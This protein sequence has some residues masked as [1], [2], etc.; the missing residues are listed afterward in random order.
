MTSAAA[1]VKAIDPKHRKSNDGYVCRC[2]VHDDRKASLKV[3]D[4]KD[5]KILVHCHAGCDSRDIIAELDRRGLWPKIE[6]EQRKPPRPAND[7]LPPAANDDQPKAKVKPVEVAKYEYFDHQTG[8]LMMQ[9]I[10]YEPKDF[11]QRRPESQPPRRVELDGRRGE[12]HPLQRPAR[13]PARQGHPRR[14]GREGRRQ[15]RRHRRRRGLQP[16]RRGQVAGQLLRDPARQGRRAGAG[17]RPAD[18]QEGDR[19]ADVAR[20][21]PPQAC[22]TGSRRSGRREAAGHRQVGQDPAPAGHAGRHRHQ[23]LAGDRRQRP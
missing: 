20:R 7:Q 11:R 5:G 1:I 9:V 3:S 21:W 22:R 15:P 23:R 6:R 2:P 8:E 4:S 14:R 18:D 13:L 17:Q 10:R 19:R 16:R 12:P